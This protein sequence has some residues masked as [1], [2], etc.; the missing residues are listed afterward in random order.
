MVSRRHRDRAGQA[1]TTATGGGNPLVSARRP[2]RRAYMAALVAVLLV[3]ETD[4]F[5]SG[6]GTAG[7]GRRLTVAVLS[8]AGAAAL[9]WARATGARDPRAAL[10]AYLGDLASGPRRNARQLPALAGRET[11]A[12][13]GQ[14]AVAHARARAPGV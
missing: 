3:Y 11:A 8:A 14:A 4:I 9:G 1:M 12:R 7:A 6:I 10:V 2:I 13:Y 5:V